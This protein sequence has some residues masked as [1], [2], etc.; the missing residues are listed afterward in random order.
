MTL[1]IDPRGFTVNGDRDMLIAPCTRQARTRQVICQTAK[2]VDVAASN[3]ICGRAVDAPCWSAL[4]QL[5]QRTFAPATEASRLTGARTT[6]NGRN[7]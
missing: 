2:M 7:D 4:G 3:P 6:D 5:A 1:H